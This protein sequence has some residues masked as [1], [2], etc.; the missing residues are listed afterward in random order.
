[1]A[2][3]QQPT[4]NIQVLEQSQIIDH[5]K[6]FPPLSLPLSLSLNT[7]STICLP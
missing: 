7:G 3:N 2:L 4:R 6:E 1:M 5:N